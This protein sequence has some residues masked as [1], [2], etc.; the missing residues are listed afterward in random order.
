[1]IYAVTINKK[2]SYIK[3]YRIVKRIG[4]SENKLS[5]AFENLVNRLVAKKGEAGSL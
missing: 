5:K 3:V 1:M 2:Y 4:G